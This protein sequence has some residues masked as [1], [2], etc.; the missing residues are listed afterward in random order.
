MKPA[1]LFVCLGNI[2]RS[3]LAEGILRREAAARGLD[4]EVDSA[5]TGDWHLGYAPDPRTLNVA[6]SRGIDIGHLRA[7]LVGEEDFGRFTHIVAMDAMNL[8]DL[9]ALRPPGSRAEIR[10]LLDYAAEEDASDPA[11][12]RSEGNV[13]DPYHGDAAAFEETFRIV[14]LGVR[15]LVRHLEETA[16][17]ESPASGAS[18]AR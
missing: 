17:G 16:R 11:V 3:P 6:T 8:A 12:R 13:P 15:G 14:E 18:D 7:R 9:E 4:V 5:G 2:C 10:R 1:V